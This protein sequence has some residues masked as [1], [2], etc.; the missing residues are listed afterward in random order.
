MVQICHLDTGWY[1]GDLGMTSHLWKLRAWLTPSC[2][3]IQTN[4]K[5][6]A[7]AVAEFIYH[8]HGV[9]RPGFSGDY[10]S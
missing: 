1:Y 10:F 2:P 3:K 4:T 6:R 7:R 5:T 8:S 9:N